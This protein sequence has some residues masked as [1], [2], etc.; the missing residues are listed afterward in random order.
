MMYSP[1]LSCAE[2]LLK[3]LVQK[4]ALVMSDSSS[5]LIIHT[6]FLIYVFRF[7]FLTN[8]LPSFKKCSMVLKQNHGKNLRVLYCYFLSVG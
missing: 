1:E 6:S 4:I 5:P 8:M 2:Y 3:V 7:L